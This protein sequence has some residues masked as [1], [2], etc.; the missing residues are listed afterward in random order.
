MFRNVARKTQDL[1][2]GLA[3]CAL[4]TLLAHGAESLE[5]RLF[6]RAWLESLVLSILLGSA[7]RTFVRLPAKVAAGIHF[8]A[9]TLLEVAVLLLAASVSAAALLEKGP[10]LIAAIAAVVALTI[11]CSFAIGRA[12]GL[13]RKMAILIACGNSICGNSAIAAVAPV[14]AADGEDVAAAIGF[15]AVLGVLVVLALP[16]LVPALAFSPTQYGVF[17]GLTVYAVPQVLAATGSVS[18]LSVHIGTLV[19][20]VRVL[21]LGPVVLLLSLFGQQ[22][23]G[24]RPALAHLLPWFIVGFLLLMGLRSAGLLPEAVLQPAQWTAN[25]LTI[26]S[27]AALGLGVDARA[28]LKAG[29]RVTLA[30]L[31]SLLVLAAI[32][33]AAIALLGIA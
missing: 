22:R 5:A 2:P 20:L 9:K 1:L 19:K 32:S 6:G 16:L 27:M 7:L 26:M 29:G 3:L 10:A 24:A 14:I 25:L 4:V 11:A 31:L 28:V 12:L 17:A 8:G 21:M 18:L 15:T 30:V 33:L 13:P 23:G